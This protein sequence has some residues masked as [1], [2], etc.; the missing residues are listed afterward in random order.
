MKQMY[1]VFCA[2]IDEY[3]ETRIFT[4]RS[5][6]LCI[7]TAYKIIAQNIGLVA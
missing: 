7:Y 2:C 1:V 6:S 3:T 5:I 4:L